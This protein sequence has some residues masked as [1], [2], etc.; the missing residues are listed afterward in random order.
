M[1][2]Y[3]SLIQYTRVVDAV[4]FPQN[5]DEPFL[6]VYFSENSLLTSD[7]PKLSLRRPDVR[8]VII[9]RT[10]IPITRLTP[11]IRNAYKQHG[12]LPFDSNMNFPKNKNLLYDTTFFTSTIDKIYKPNTYR[13]RAGYLIQNML[14]KTFQDF[15]ANYKKILIYSVNTTRPLNLLIEKSLH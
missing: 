7:Y 3:K 9:P 11:D 1:I 14:I 2:Q 10:K 13:Q 8:H 5:V 15:P 12:L 4:R 6:L